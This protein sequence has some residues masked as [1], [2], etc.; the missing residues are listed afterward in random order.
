MDIIRK[1]RLLLKATS[2]VVFIITT[3]FQAYSQCPTLAEL[4]GTGTYTINTV[5]TVYTDNNPDIGAT[6]TI[7]SG[8]SLVFDINGNGGF[9]GLDIDG[10]TV[11]VENGG[12][13]TVQR[14]AGGGNAQLFIREGSTLT[15]DPGGIVNV[16]DDVQVG[17]SGEATTGFL[18]LNGTLNVGGDF[19]LNG[20]G[21][22]AG[23]GT[24]SGSGTLDVTGDIVEDEPAANGDA[25]WTGN[26]TCD[27]TCDTLPVKLSNFGT[28]DKTVDQVTFEWSTVSELNNEGFY[29]EKS[30]DNISYE[31]LTF[32]AGN[33]TTNEIQKYSYTDLA[34]DRSAFYRLKQIDYDGQF[35]Y[36]PVL[37]VTHSNHQQIELLQNPVRSSFQFVGSD[38]LE[39]SAVLL[40]I[41]GKQICSI[42]RGDIKEV[43]FRLNQIVGTLDPAIYL[44]KVQSADGNQ[45]LRFIKE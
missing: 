3:T 34:F 17:A 15:I 22:G 29:L 25:G 12:T 5:C 45:T 35:E 1:G 14:E 43:E 24:L 19:N 20:T 7:E 33:G 13:L 32:V 26:S 38:Q 16:E 11:T 21:A 37:F 39:Y 18:V 42:I 23:G 41:S 8:G 27:G 36:H 10:G 4:Q 40:T 30:L 6:V 44:L 2:F 31:T 9:D 28:T